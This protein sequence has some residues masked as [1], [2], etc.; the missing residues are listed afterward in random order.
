MIGWKGML[1][2]IVS[3]VLPV[4]T[5]HRIRY[6]HWYH[7]WP[8]LD[9]PKR[10]TEKMMWLTYYNKKYNKKL[11]Q[12]TYDK[13]LVREY[14]KNKGLESILVP[15]YG[16]YKNAGE[17]DFN[18]LPKEYILKATQSSGQNIIVI[19]NNKLNFEQ[20]TRHIEKWLKQKKWVDR[21]QGYYYTKEETINC[22]ELLHDSEGKIPTDIR[23][24]C[25]NGKAKWIYC[26]IDTTDERMKH[27][28]AYNREYFDTDWNY[29]PVDNKNRT[30]I[31]KDNP[32][33][34][35][36]ENLKRIIDVAEKLAGDFVF[37]RVD[38][39]DINNKI[40][41]GEL[42]PIPG[43]HGGFQPDEWDYT[44]GEMIDLPNIRIW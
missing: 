44:F 21:F 23:V 11:I 9:D 8:D 40:Y 25:C 29:L 17:I 43:V 5:A 14:V 38:L 28:S 30:R 1:F 27:K 39:Y 4:K 20:I 31:D 19:D 41:F 13:Y 37:V 16:N 22:E 32:T 24:C 3:T 7:K 18:T 26:D 34:S 12:R 35:K 42:T 2:S 36:P 6:Y 10:F 33:L 15:L